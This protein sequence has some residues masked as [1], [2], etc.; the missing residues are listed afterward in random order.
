MINQGMTGQDVNRK[1]FP[2]SPTQS[3]N[4]NLRNEI[5]AIDYKLK[6]IARTEAARLE[7]EVAESRI[8]GGPN[9]MTLEEAKKAYAE[10]R[11]VS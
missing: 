5:T 2:S 9:H 1:L 11:E 4:T 3:V 6:R 8:Y 7:D 10:G